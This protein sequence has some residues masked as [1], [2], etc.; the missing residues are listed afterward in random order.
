MITFCYFFMTLHVM[1]HSFLRA[2]STGNF[3]RFLNKYPQKTL[4]KEE[5]CDILCIWF[6]YIFK[7]ELSGLRCSNSKDNFCGRVPRAGYVVRFH[8]EVALKFYF[9]LLKDFVLSHFE[10]LFWITVRFHFEPLWDSIWIA[11][12]FH[13][14]SLWYFVL[15]SFKFKLYEIYPLVKNFVR[16]LIR[17][18][19][20]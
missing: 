19:R 10:I 5:C 9:K 8:F 7:L 4:S 20:P 16:S 11:V 14:E 3:K 18:L 12:R 17:T 2:T 13:F 1:I 15:K 6:L